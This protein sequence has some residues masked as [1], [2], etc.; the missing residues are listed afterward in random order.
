VALLETSW[1][2]VELVDEHAAAIIAASAKTPSRPQKCPMTLML[3]PSGMLRLFL[4]RAGPP[5]SGIAEM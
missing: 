5:N 2:A 1:L 4:P 3:R